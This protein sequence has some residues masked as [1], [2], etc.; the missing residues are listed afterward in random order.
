[1]FTEQGGTIGRAGTS[2]WVLTHNKVSARHAVITCRGGV[3]YIQDTSRN[4]VSINSPDNRLVRE[5]PYPLHEG[6]CIFI[7]PYE[8]EVA[9]DAD[10]GRVAG[11]PIDPFGQD[12]PF[13]PGPA[14]S[15]GFRNPIPID[16][17]SAVPDV[18]DFFPVDKPAARRHPA[19]VASAGDDLL[20]SHV[21]P[22]VATPDP[23]LRQSDPGIIP[24]GYNPLAPDD[25]MGGGASRR[26][27]A[28]P[29]RDV[30]PPPRPRPG[31]VVARDIP[32]LP[33]PPAPVAPVPAIPEPVAPPPAPVRL[34]PV[35]IAPPPAPAAPVAAP[36]STE[37]LGSR[38][39]VNVLIGAGVKDAVVTPEL[40]SNLGK[41]LRV[42]VAGV[43]EVLRARRRI[44]EEFR[45][46]DTIFRPIE[47]N[48]L[49]VSV[50]VDDALH[51]L[52]VKRNAAYLGAVDAFADALSDVRSH[53]L[54]ML[55]GMRVAFDTMLAEFDPD[56]LQEEFDRQLAKVSLP[57]VPAKR[58]YWDLFREKRLE[59][60]K[61]PEKTFVD[62]FGEA[63]R[64]AYEEQF[65]T[66][67]AEARS[68]AAAGP[69]DSPPPRD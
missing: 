6:D 24:H 11:Q 28:Q 15:I 36:A 16:P 31:N 44:K 66:L 65:R 13:A 35:S 51:N 17:E 3:F 56:R 32:P 67:K 61:D 14:S 55:T 50:N 29:G 5:R 2:S 12:D 62:L 59:M 19:P 25:S 26:P 45:M 41:I 20:S 47:N 68:G 60:A 69:L 38:D 18:L 33:P 21:D 10:A 58:R 57:L 40:A 8:I 43:M 7:E 34:D 1:V 64:R 39:I 37:E 46:R 49:K 9:V 30:A 53:E 22:Q 48:P 42:V 4:G 27:R 63:F 23:A 54:A 52:L